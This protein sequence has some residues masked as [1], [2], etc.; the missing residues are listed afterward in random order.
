MAYLASGTFTTGQLIGASDLN[1]QIRDNEAYLLNGRQLVANTWLKGSNTT[2]T[3]AT[4]TSIDATDQHARITVP[5]TASGRV[6]IICSF[7]ANTSANTGQFRLSRDAGTE[8]SGDATNGDIGTQNTTASTICFEAVFIGLSAAS[9][10]FDLQFRVNATVA[11]VTHLGTLVPIKMI[12]YE[13]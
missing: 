1:Q 2:N 3:T 10:T 4:F 5:A 8:F 11:T 13:I 6:R 12:A 7:Q 9:H